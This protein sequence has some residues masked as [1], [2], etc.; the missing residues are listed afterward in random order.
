LTDTKVGNTANY[1]PT[2]DKDT[3]A[4]TY[5]YCGVWAEK[6]G[7]TSDVV[8]SDIATIKSMYKYSVDLS[9]D[10]STVTVGQYPT[11]TATAKVYSTDGTVGIYKTTTAAVAL[12][13]SVSSGMHS[14]VKQSQQQHI[15]VDR[16]TY[17]PV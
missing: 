15:T 5:Y 6:N 9:V 2:V 12:D 4:T 8:Y 7:V 16:Y 1:T 17:L 10:D 11:I 3:P 13:Y 14:S